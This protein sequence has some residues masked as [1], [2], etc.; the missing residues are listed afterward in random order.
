MEFRSPRPWRGIVAVACA[1]TAV[2]VTPRQASA[3]TIDAT[4]FAGL[5]YPLYDQQLTLRPGAPSIPGVD[6]SV[7]SSPVLRGDGGAVFGA[8]LA[9][10]I[11]IVGLEGRLDSMSVGIDFSGARYD[12]RG[13]SFPFDGVTASIIASPG[14]FDTDRIPVL[15]LNARIRTPGSVGFLASGGLSYLRDITVT[16][17]VPLDV[18]APALPPLGFSAGLTLRATPE[19]SGHRFGL[20]G[21]AGVRIGGRVGLVAEVRA[22]YFRDYE[23]R[24]G[25]SNGPELLDDLLAEADP[26]RFTPVFVNAQV[27]LSFRF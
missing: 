21:G 2:L 19:Q 16:G 12:L 18:E 15:S 17:S 24:F 3:Q 5:A 14:Q 20:N 23:L 11:G 22:F 4:V 13:T 6:V 27:G 9:L 1:A 10:E 7:A 25:T 8:A 26:V